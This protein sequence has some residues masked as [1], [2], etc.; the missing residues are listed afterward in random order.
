MPQFTINRE[1]VGDVVVNTGYVVD[2]TTTTTGTFFVGNNINE[3][4]SPDPDTNSHLFAQRFAGGSGRNMIIENVIDP[5]IPS[6]WMKQFKN[7]LWDSEDGPFKCT[8]NADTAVLEFSDETNTIFTAPAG[9]IPI[10]GR[11]ECS[12]GAASGSFGNFEY[13]VEVH[14]DIFFYDYLI[15]I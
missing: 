10:Y 15:L 12:A 8:V 11:F 7:Q 14:C 3:G 13:I 5:A 1:P 2:L 9:S 6:G 4:A